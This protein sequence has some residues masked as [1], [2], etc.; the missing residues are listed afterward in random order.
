LYLGTGGLIRAYTDAAQNALMA[1]PRVERIERRRGMVSIPYGLYERVKNLAIEV[2]G[3]IASED[4]GV[5]VTLELVFAT[6]KVSTFEAR[7]TELSAGSVEL[8]WGDDESG[9]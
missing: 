5:D 4:F 3:E 2:D 7:L 8:L 9:N 6:D 1:L